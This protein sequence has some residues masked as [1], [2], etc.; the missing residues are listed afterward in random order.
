MTEWEA[1]ILGIIQGLT[2]FLPVSSSG[3]LELGKSLLGIHLEGDLAFTVLV[4]GATVLSTII[5]F[6]EEIKRLLKGL[7]QFKWNQET[8]YVLLLAISMFPVLIVG[9]FFKEQ[10]EAYFFDSIVLV[11]VMLW[12]TGLLLLF[13]RFKKGK[14]R[15]LNGFDAL[16]IGIA[17]A[18]AVI[19]GISRSGATI[20]TSLMLGNSREEATRFSFLMVLVPIIGANL[21]DF[22]DYTAGDAANSWTVYLAGFLAAFISGLFACQWMIKLVKQQKLIYFAFYCFL[23][24]LLAIVLG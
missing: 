1:V 3:H 19:P 16:V 18:I 20:S 23:V 6:R 10:V 24:G 13:T 21:L 15:S 9:L 4:H 17:Q 22:K 12:V 8:H 2:E 5:I 7:L 14:E 11:G